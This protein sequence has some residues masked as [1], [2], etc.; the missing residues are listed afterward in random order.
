MTA[1]K[2]A[3]NDEGFQGRIM[4]QHAAAAKAKEA[5]V[6]VYEPGRYAAIVAMP[7]N[8]CDLGCA[9]FP[10]LSNKRDDIDVVWMVAVQINFHDAL[11]VE[12]RRAGR[13]SRFRQTR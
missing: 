9:H 1:V 3:A 12:A 5:R 6:R 2:T 7:M 8:E 10:T 11:L 4:P 13:G